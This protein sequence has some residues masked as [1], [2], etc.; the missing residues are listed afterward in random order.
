MARPA[1]S[2]AVI[3]E[4][5]KVAGIRLKLVVRGQK[6]SL[7]GTLPPKPGE[8]KAKQTYLA[9][10]LDHTPYGLKTSEL[11]AH[12]L[13]AQLGQGSF[14]WEN[15]TTI[16]L[17]TCEAW[18][19]RYKR[20]WFEVHGDTPQT[21]TKWKR[22]EWQMGLRWLPSTENLS[23]SVLEQTVLE[24]PANTRARQLCIQIL[25]RFAEFASLPVDLNK[26]RGK[27]TSGSKVLEIPSDEEIAQ[28][29]STIKNPQWRLV[30]ARMA[31][32]GLRNHECWLCEIESTP[33][34]KCRVLDGKTG[35][36]DGVMPFYPEWAEQWK[37]WE[38]TLPTVTD[39]KGDRAIYGERTARAFKRQKIPFTPYTLRHAW[40]IRAT[41]V[42]KQPIPV[43][44]AMAG[45][46]AD[47]HLRTYNRW[48]KA[49]Q[50]FEAYR[51]AIEKGPKAPPV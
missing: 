18:I 47:L 14:R 13:W 38:G 12:E 8:A 31:I 32:Y 20:H 25:K 36:R 41:V 51:E 1:D 48:L 29:Y 26:F 23:A 42:F 4:R 9:L 11:K 5:L 50:G 35:P 2:L 34:Y 17:E 24:R 16:E 46:S 37:P 19:N 28:L 30:Y 33:P 45:H 10:G 7:R 21:Q 44:A 39:S 3:N 15:W 40:C 43:S 6:I 49:S 27:Y 22:Q